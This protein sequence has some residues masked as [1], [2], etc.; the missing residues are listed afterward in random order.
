MRLPSRSER[1][2]QHGH[3]TRERNTI[4]NAQATSSTQEPSVDPSKRP[5]DGR[6]QRGT[7]IGI[8]YSDGP[9]EANTGFGTDRGRRARGE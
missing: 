7:T 5:S 9:D 6:Y 4:S 2:S 1:D 8:P 3:V